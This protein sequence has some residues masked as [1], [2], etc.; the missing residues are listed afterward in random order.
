MCLCSLFDILYTLHTHIYYS[1]NTVAKGAKIEGFEKGVE[2]SRNLQGF[3][4]SNTLVPIGSIVC[5]ISLC[6]LL[7]GA[8]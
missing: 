8:I 1:I 6:R 5:Y 4:I 7:Q 3:Q 2:K